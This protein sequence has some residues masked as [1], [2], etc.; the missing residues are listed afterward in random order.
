VAVIEVEAIHRSRAVVVGNGN[1]AVAARHGHE[2]FAN[3]LH[4][5]AS[6]YRHRDH[7]SYRWSVYHR[8]ETDLLSGPDLLTH[9]CRSGDDVLA[10]R[11][12]AE[13]AV[14][15]LVEGSPLKTAILGA[16][17]EGTRQ[18]LHVRWHNR[19]RVHRIDRR[20]GR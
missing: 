4:G 15:C 16:G 13:V 8:D 9:Q 3:R 20:P 14:E 17:R 10:V 1:A 18:P 5:D 2:S 11:D 6:K 12:A 19:R 7:D